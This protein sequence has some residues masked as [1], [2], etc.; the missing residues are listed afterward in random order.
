MIGDFTGNDFDIF[1]IG[2]LPA[3]PTGDFNETPTMRAAIRE[4]ESSKMEVQAAQAE[5]YPTLQITLTAGALGVDPPATFGE[6]Y[7]ASYDGVVSMPIFQGGLITSHI[8]Q[9]KAKQLQAIAQARSTEYQLRRSIDE[10]RLRYQRA[11]D[12]IRNSQPRAT[13]RRRCIRADLDTLSWRRHRDPAR[14]A[15]R[16]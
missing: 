9:A 15:G 11:L 13:R 16:L 2:E 5:R 8:D 10:A 3:M 12:R 14:G 1:D 4:I 7:W 6:Y